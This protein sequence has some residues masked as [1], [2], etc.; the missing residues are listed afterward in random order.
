MGTLIAIVLPWIVWSPLVRGSLAITAF[1]AIAL[2]AAFHGWGRLVARAAGV[3]VGVALAI[4][5]G[6]AAV[7][8]IAG[9]LIALHLYDPRLLVIAGL[10]A[11][12]TYVAITRP[13]ENRDRSWRFWLVPAAV[14]AVLAVV[15]VL[16]AA[17]S[18]RPFDDDGNVVA[19]VQR[20]IDSGALADAIGYPRISQLGGHAVLG[21]LAAAFGEVRAVR[22]IDGGL[23][24]VL[25]LTLAIA[26]IRP[27]DA[28]GALWAT[29][30]VITSSAFAIAGSDLAP[31]WIPAGLIV[32]LYAS[33]YEAGDDA[34]AMLPIALVAGAICALR[35]ELVPLA[36][37]MTV[38]T[39]R[40]HARSWREDRHRI[41][42]LVGGLVV[43]VVPFVIARAAAWSAVGSGARGLL[44]APHAGLT[45]RL[46][47]FAVVAAAVALPLLAIIREHED[48]ALRWLAVGV[49]AGIAGVASHLVGEAA[50]ATHLLWPIAVAACVVL[51]IAVARRRE[52][53][54]L[55]SVLAALGCV[56]LY[57]GQTAIHSAWSSRYYELLG[58]V[59]Y[60]RHF[61]PE[62]GA[63]D[64]VLA[65][66][67]RGEIVAVWVARPE[68]LDYAQ[69]RIVDL[70]TPRVAPLRFT[71]RFARLVEASRARWLLVERDDAVSERSWLD[72][73]RCNAGQ[74]CSDELEALVL[75]HRL[76]AQRDGVR[77]VELSG[78]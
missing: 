59:E 17:T 52:L 66:A 65:P 47:L 37:A 21:G 48:R 11:H 8:G 51:V 13:R 16:A 63:Y 67:R 35:D 38:A 34:R 75:R 45:G 28:T 4:Q 60:A 46:A 31:L 49:A 24:F 50:Y 9:V 72:R 44:E 22:M 58:D 69:H 10:G 62:G 32:A 56:L 5:W 3:D 19:Q 7:I 12:S 2:V 42:V 68:L 61:A 55:A 25:M 70:R 20:L 26:R 64:A 1:G 6:I 76:V 43:V 36:I 30:V 33:T 77:L 23:G 73:L 54:R 40:F 53:G 39:W 41:A 74:P 18:A 15:H 57:D 29:L 27:R 71:D 78:P 14:L